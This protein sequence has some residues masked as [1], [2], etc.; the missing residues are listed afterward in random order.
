MSEKKD[1][2]DYIRQLRRKGYV[3]IIGGNSHWQI[4]REGR[5]V[6]SVAATPHG[7]KRVMLNFRAKIRRFERE[8][9]EEKKYAGHA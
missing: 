6:T 7:G 3:A 8:L 5:F 9:A 2:T 4:W 1:V